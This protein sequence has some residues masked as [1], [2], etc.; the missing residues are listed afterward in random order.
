MKTEELIEFLKKHPG[1]EVLKAGGV[2]SEV[3]HP[4]TDWMVLT[5][6]GW[7]YSTYRGQKERQE[8]VIL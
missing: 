8:V 5:S 3:A 6:E 4:T 2:F 7:R 1:K